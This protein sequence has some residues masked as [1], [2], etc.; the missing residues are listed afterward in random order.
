MPYKRK[1]K[2]RKPESEKHLHRHIMSKIGGINSNNKAQLRKIQ[3]IDTSTEK[4]QVPLSKFYMRIKGVWQYKGM[5]CR[6][7]ET[8]LVDPEVIDKHRY[9][10]KA[11]NKK[12]EE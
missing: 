8:L 10:C 11:I 4:P 1:P 9:I 6:L 7:C 12:Q 3:K 5:A 2:P